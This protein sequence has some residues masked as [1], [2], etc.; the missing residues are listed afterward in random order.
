M[1]AGWIVATRCGDTNIVVAETRLADADR[2]AREWGTDL[3]EH[4]ARDIPPCRRV[5]TVNPRGGVTV[6]RRRMRPVQQRIDLPVLPER[7]ERS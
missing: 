6:A 5:L 3:R 4:Y 7:A 1:Q 2:V